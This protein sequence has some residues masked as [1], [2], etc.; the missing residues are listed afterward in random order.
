MMKSID[1]GGLRQLKEP[2]QLDTAILFNI[3]VILV[4]KLDK[5]Q[6]KTEP[7]NAVS[8]SLPF[9]TNQHHNRMANVRKPFSFRV[10]RQRKSQKQS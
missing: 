5:E 8:F 3:N 9:P 1:L 7:S 4:L 2:L 10:K 6:T